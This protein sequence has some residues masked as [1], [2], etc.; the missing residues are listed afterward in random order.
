MKRIS[1]GVILII[2]LVGAGYAQ[3]SSGDF[4]IN[5]EDSLSHFTH[6]NPLLFPD[7]SKGFLIVWE[8][9]RNGSKNYFAQRCD[10]LGK[11]IGRNFPFYSNAN[12]AFSQDGSFFVLGE[13]NI[14]FD[15]PFNTSYYYLKG[16]ICQSNGTWSEPVTIGSGENPWCGTGFVGYFHD[17]TTFSSGYLI[18]FNSDGFLTISKRGWNSDTL[19]SW[20]NQ[21]SY[22]PDDTTRPAEISL[23][24]NN[25]G[26]F[27]VVWFNAV[28]TDSLRGICGTF[29]SN[30]DSV[31][32]ENVVLK[33]SD[34]LGTNSSFWDW[35]LKLLPVADSLYEI[36]AFNGMTLELKYWKVDRRGNAVG[37]TNEI[38]LSPGGEY[39]PNSYHSVK[40]YSFS[41]LVNDEFSL[42]VS[43]VHPYVSGLTLSTSLF[44]FNKNGDLVGNVGTT[45][46]DEFTSGDWFF[47]M[48]DGSILLPAAN[49]GE[50]LLNTYRD[51]SLIGNR[52]INEEIFGSNDLASG[53]SH[54]GTDAYFVTWK[55]EKN[56]LGRKID[57]T[58]HPIGTQGI[59]NGDDI[60]YFPNGSAITLWR[61]LEGDSLS[62]LGYS[63]FNQSMSLMTS[64][65]LSFFSDPT[66]LYGTL[67]IWSDSAFTILYR[68]EGNAVHVRNVNLHSGDEEITIP[69]TTNPINLQIIEENDST[70][71]IVY[72]GYL[73]LVSKSLNL[74]EQ[75]RFLQFAEYLGN[76]RFL[77]LSLKYSF[78]LYY[79][80]TIVSLNDD[81]VSTDFTVADHAD[82][83]V[84][85]SLSKDYFAAVYRAE[86]T[87]YI[88]V[89]TSQ[90]QP[91]GEPFTVSS[92]TVSIKCNP[93][94]CQHGNSLLVIWSEAR[95]PGNGY[96]VYGRVFDID[97]ITSVENRNPEIEHDFALQQ[98]YP[99]PFN[100]ASII[101]YRLSAAVHVTLMVYD[102]LGREV[103]TIVDEKQTRG[104][105][106]VVFDGGG[107]PSGVYFY[108]LRTAAFVMT[109]KMVMVK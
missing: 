105:H 97:E 79:T 88:R 84:C 108:Q 40:N 50:I 68:S 103:K 45:S 10:S 55:D 83:I 26:D 59:Y 52:K 32:A 38:L 2:V 101:S 93:L 61:K 95:T 58:G 104:N 89:F 76:Q 43:I 34:F 47:R 25:N 1:I 28:E 78:G 72:S 106:E 29:F 85:K 35:H 66:Y 86:E 15:P 3:H 18:A 73:R 17:I 94:V 41:P 109:K 65:T 16:R 5:Q 24:T 31:I 87:I 14:S 42:I 7:G 19:W 56:Y 71:W 27:A 98:N 81:T 4:L 92:N 9:Y 37:M 6:A 99:N 49:D 54:Y 60:Q 39:T 80:G 62:I 64:D 22:T 96:D 30:E 91:V 57:N 8:D 82:A 90:G 33:T 44:T 75:E 12:V 11:P 36:F 51:F 23:S 63:L 100:P 74:L 20:N 69:T 13:G 102:V 48:S 107:L 53:I 46:M 21:Y 67:K 77:C 70:F